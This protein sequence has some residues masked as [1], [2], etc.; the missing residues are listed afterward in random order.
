VF[1]YA[2]TGKRTQLA[3]VVP[4]AQSSRKEWTLPILHR[5]TVVPGYHYGKLIL[6]IR[7]LG[8]SGMGAKRGGRCNAF[9]PAW[10]QVF[11]ANIRICASGRWLRYWRFLLKS[12]TPMKAASA[13]GSPVSSAASRLCPR[14]H[15]DGR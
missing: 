13:F 2:K 1:G 15:R 5:R 7:T 4:K 12:L 11:F 9:D 3:S 10:G 8:N 14:R 6:H